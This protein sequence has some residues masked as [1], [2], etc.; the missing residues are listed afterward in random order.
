MSLNSGG[1]VV[2]LAPDWAGCEWAHFGGTGGIAQVRC[3]RGPMGNV[4]FLDCVVL[5]PRRKNSLWKRWGC[6][7]ETRECGQAVGNAPWRVVHGLS[8]RPEGR[9]PVRKDSSTNPRLGARVRNTPPRDAP[10]S[11]RRPVMPPPG[12]LGR[13][14]GTRRRGRGLPVR[15]PPDRSWREPVGP[16]HRRSRRAASTARHPAATSA[17]RKA[18]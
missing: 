16:R 3:W 12:W 10:R 18:S 17:S 4:A 1:V 15:S 9:A 5:L 14:P 6:G 11:S 13:W 2:S 7:R 8:P